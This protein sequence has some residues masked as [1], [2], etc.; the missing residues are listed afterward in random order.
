[1]RYTVHDRPGR[2]LALL[3]FS[4]AARKLAPRDRLIGWT[5]ALREK[6]LPK[7][8]DNARFRILARIEIP[9]L[10]SHVLS[11]VCRQLIRDGSARYNTTPV[12]IGPRRRPGSGTHRRRGS[13]NR[14]PGTAARLHADPAPSI[15]SLPVVG[16]VTGK[17]KIRRDFRAPKHNF[18][19][20]SRWFLRTAY[21]FGHLF[22][23]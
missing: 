10:A 1:M 15:A 9:N 7:V 22:I 19:T 17:P 5:P 3:G 4:T 20:T 6:N 2:L 23:S 11:V 21:R 14:C 12:L 16:T 8:I 18:C 13:T